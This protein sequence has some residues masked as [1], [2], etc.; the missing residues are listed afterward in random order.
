[1]N[2]KVQYKRPES[3]LILI[4]TRQGE[5]LLLRRADVPAFWQSVTGSLESEE[6][7]FAALCRELT[8]ETGL[9]VQDGELMDCDFHTWFDVWPAF[10]SRYAPEV[11]FNH[12]HA[13]RLL[14]P[15]KINDILLNEREH[16][17][18]CWLPKTQAITLATSCSNKEV[19][20]RFCPEA[21]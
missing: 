12:E 5:V 15:E 7:P 20:R 14:L 21:V 11:T 13:Y 6:T 2:R 16:L 10:R 17:D 8:E 1:M 18:Y 19:I 9:H 3:V 4:C